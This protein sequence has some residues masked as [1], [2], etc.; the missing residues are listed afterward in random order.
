M[1]KIMSNEI[2]IMSGKKRVQAY[3]NITAFVVVV[4]ETGIEQYLSQSDLLRRSWTRT[5]ENNET[6]YIT[7]TCYEVKMPVT[8]K[9]VYIK[10]SMGTGT[11]K[12]K[13]VINLLLKVNPYSTKVIELKDKYNVCKVKFNGEL[14]L[15]SSTVKSI[16][17]LKKWFTI[18]KENLK[19]NKQIN[20]Q[21]LW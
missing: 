8:L 2:Y 12:A 7:E 18:V 3:T 16:E 19:P 11:L 21:I 17:D 14:E 5:I 13:E 6:N 1:N 20:R 15:K 9:L 10:N 4:G